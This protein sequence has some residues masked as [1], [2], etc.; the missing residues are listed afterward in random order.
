MGPGRP[1]GSV[2]HKLTDAELLMVLDNVVIPEVP[3]HH[4]C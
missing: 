2:M 3:V 1:K 4:G